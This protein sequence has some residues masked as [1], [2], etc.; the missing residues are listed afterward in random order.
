MEL[1]LV[2]AVVPVYDREPLFLE[3]VKSILHQ[4]YSNIHIY[5]IEDGSQSTAKYS[6]YFKNW[7]NI[8]LIR[9]NTN[10]GVSYCRNLG[11][12][13]GK[14]EYVAFLDSDDLWLPD[15]ISKQIVFLRNNPMHKWVHTDEVWL[16]NGAEVFQK[17]EHSKQG[18]IFFERLIQRCIISPSSVLFEKNFFAEN[19]GFLNH[20]KVAEDYELWLR[21]NLKYPVGFINEPLTVKRSGNWEQLSQTI[22]IDRWRVLALHRIFRIYKNTPEFQKY[23]A[24]LKKEILKKTKI[25]A[26]GAEKYGHHAKFSKYQNWLKVFNTF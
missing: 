16:K 17:K 15:K 6:Y 14:G 25:L 9:L 12:S 2:D 21:L 5:I 22:E 23:I 24:N 18:G 8:T 19:H 13:L 11:A 20:F 10:H 26:R 1:P 3:A 7:N 4:D